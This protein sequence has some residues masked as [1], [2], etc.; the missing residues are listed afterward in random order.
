[1][2]VAS[3][4]IKMVEIAD[5]VHIVAPLQGRIHTHTSSFFHDRDSTATDLA[6]NLLKVKPQTTTHSLRSTTVWNW[7]S[8]TQDSSIANDMG[9]R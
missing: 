9:W 2:T 5:R 1:M 4:L 8:Q 3:S 7:S 6:M